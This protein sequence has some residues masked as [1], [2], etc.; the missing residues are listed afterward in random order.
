MTGCSE[1]EYEAFQKDWHR[2]L[3]ESGLA[4]ASWPREWGGEDLSLELQIVIFQEIALANAPRQV[5]YFV[6]MNHIPGTFLHWGTEEQKQRYLTG[7]KKGDVWCQGFS[8]PNAGSDLASLR[9]KAVKD[10][11]KYVVNGQKVWSSN[12]MFADYCLL[13]ARTDP[14]APKHKGLSLFAMDMHSEGIEVRHIKQASGMTEFC[15]VFLNDVR[16]PEENLIGP[17]NQGWLVSQT[18]LSTERSLPLVELTL[19]MSGAFTW[20]V[21]LVRQQQKLDDTTTRLRLAEIGAKLETLE[22]MIRRTM[23]RSIAGG[24]TNA[25]A[26]YLKIYYSELLQEFTELCVDF[27]GLDGQ[28]ETPFLLGG[29]QET[30]NWMFDYL[31]SWMWTIAGGTNEIIRNIIAERIL[32][33]PR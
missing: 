2:K 25:E 30:G 33:L 6:S 29:G 32:G 26:S 7:V 21:N 3:V 16:I 28:L 9:T 19:R 27:E 31:N 10:G 18:T 15:E 14:E 1:S 5:I 24:D 11:D 17:E 20:L 22:L 23:S 13:L 8:E 4:T 12:A